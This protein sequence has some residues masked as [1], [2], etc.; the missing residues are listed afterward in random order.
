MATAKQLGLRPGDIV[1]LGAITTFEIPYVDSNG[2]IHYSQTRREL[3]MNRGPR[4]QIVWS[5]TDHIDPNVYNEVRYLDDSPRTVIRDGEPFMIPSMRA[6]D[7]DFFRT[8]Y[9][10]FIPESLQRKEPHPIIRIA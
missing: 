7:I 8:D 10:G 1:R 5:Y 2:V 9:T 4:V 6:G 3:D